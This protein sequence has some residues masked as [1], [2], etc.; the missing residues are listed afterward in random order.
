MTAAEASTVTAAAT[1]ATAASLSEIVVINCSTSS[2]IEHNRNDDKVGPQCDQTAR[3]FVQYLAIYSNVNL[4]NSNN[5]FCQTR[6]GKVFDN[7]RLKFQEWS[8]T[9]M[10]L[11]N[12]RNFAAKFGHTGGAGGFFRTFQLHFQLAFKNGKKLD[13]LLQFVINKS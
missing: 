3:L 8:E 7:Y 9:F 5:L 10:S 13:V 4:S 12:W 1:A 6:L 2:S 11:P